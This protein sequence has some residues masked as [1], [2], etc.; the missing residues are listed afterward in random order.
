VSR[1]R[2]SR[3]AV[4][5]AGPDAV[6]LCLLVDGQP[7]PYGCA[8]ASYGEPLQPG[9]TTA[10]PRGPVR[11]RFRARRIAGPSASPLREPRPGVG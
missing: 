2:A 3:P 6:H 4:R 1:R 8:W 9:P 11:Y 7:T 10:G 5:S